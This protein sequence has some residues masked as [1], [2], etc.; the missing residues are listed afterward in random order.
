MSREK[1]KSLEEGMSKDPNEQQAGGCLAPTRELAVAAP[2][3][4][5]GQALWERPLNPI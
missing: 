4:L 2:H 3:L 5:V 1:K